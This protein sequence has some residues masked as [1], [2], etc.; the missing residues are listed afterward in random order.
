MRSFIGARS[1]SHS[2]HRGGVATPRGQTPPGQTT[3]L[4]DNPSLPVDNP[5]ADTP[6]PS[7]CY[8]THPLRAVHAGIRSTSGRYAS[9]W[10]AFL[11]FFFGGHQSFFFSKLFFRLK[12][13]CLPRR[14]LCQIIKANSGK[15]SHNVYSLSSQNTNNNKTNKQKQLTKN[16]DSQCLIQNDKKLAKDQVHTSLEDKIIYCANHMDWHIQGGTRGA[17]PP[18]SVQFFLFPCSF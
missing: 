16:K 5:W 13:K 1:V 14:K 9:H 8:D 18:P 6:V 7:A 3:P 17:R 15:T 10:N 4:A 12:L 11:L 2:V